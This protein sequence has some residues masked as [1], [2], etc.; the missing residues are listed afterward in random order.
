MAIKT[1]ML[2]IEYNDETDT[3]EYL[4]EEVIGEPEEQ[5]E[6][7]AIRAMVDLEKYFDKDI[8][9]YI[10]RTYIVGET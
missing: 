6:G 4:Q 2:T 7:D 3:I 5:K 1:Y 9:E 8:L 10:R